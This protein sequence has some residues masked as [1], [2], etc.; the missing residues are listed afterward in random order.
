MP[1][2]GRETDFFASSPLFGTITGVVGRPMDGRNRGD[3]A[4][5]SSRKLCVRESDIEA[6]EP[7]LMSLISLSYD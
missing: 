2:I 7:I 1:L 4:Y 5:G 6:P 3:L